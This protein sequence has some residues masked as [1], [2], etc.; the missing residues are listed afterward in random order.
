MY[1]FFLCSACNLTNP[2]SASDATLSPLFMFFSLLMFFPLKCHESVKAIRRIRRFI[3]DNIFKRLVI[4][5][6]KRIDKE[7]DIRKLPLLIS[8]KSEHYTL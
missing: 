5:G 7:G 4:S 1:T 3:I 2:H 6:F 8:G